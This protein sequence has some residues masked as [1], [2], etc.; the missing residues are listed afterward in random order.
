MVKLVGISNVTAVNLSSILDVANTSDY[1]T[2]LVN[3]NS[4]VYEGW[5]FFILFCCLWLVLFWAANQ[6]N[7]QIL[8][9]LFFSGFVVS[10]IS[11]FLRVI[12][13]SKN[14][15]FI[16]LITDRLMWM[17][18]VVTALLGLILWM[19]KKKDSG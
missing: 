6:T 16:G 7:N 14:G 10:L 3:V 8:Q 15:L 1:S 17:F 12:E 18:P 5:L 11:L 13:I 19:T 2:F 9:N 4:V